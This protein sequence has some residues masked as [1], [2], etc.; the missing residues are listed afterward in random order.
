MRKLLVAALLIALIV[1]AGCIGT[2]FDSGH[3]EFLSTKARFVSGEEFLPEMQNELE[4]FHKD[5]SAQKK[6]ATDTALVDFLDIE[7]LKIEMQQALVGGR[8]KLLRINLTDI[9]CERL[10]LGLS[11][12]QEGR[13]KGR[14]AQRLAVDFQKIH[15]GEFLKVNLERG[16]LETII[17]QTE[18]TIVYVNN[19]KQLGC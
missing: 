1:L 12:L 2:G 10:Q 15:P 9:D 6:A 7:L 3:A 14:K 13:D 17:L 19:L 11:L 18:N 4:L 8:A 5:L 16:R